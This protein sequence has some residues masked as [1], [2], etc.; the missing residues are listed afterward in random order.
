MSYEVSEW[1][2][3][4]YG[5]SAN[6]R[7]GEFI[8]FVRLAID[9]ERVAGA[10]GGGSTAAESGWSSVLLAASLR[11]LPSAS[12]SA[13]WSHVLPFVSGSF[14]AKNRRNAASTTRKMRNTNGPMRFCAH[15]CNIGKPT[16]KGSQGSRTL[17]IFSCNTIEQHSCMQYFVLIK[18]FLCSFEQFKKNCLSNVCCS[19][20]R[21]YRTPIT[22][23]FLV[24]GQT[25]IG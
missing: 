21:L 12:L 7:L 23:N 9:Q 19:S 3:A 22:E 2:Y 1:A 11:W 15:E 18:Q 4:Y 5:V 24:V 14:T 8:N 17:A 6:V 10:E 13:I 16:R 20:N 25:L